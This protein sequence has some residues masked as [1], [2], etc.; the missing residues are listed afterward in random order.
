MFL[1]RQVHSKHES[2][3]NFINYRLQ[4]FYNNSEL[5]FVF[6][7]AHCKALGLRKMIDISIGT[8]IEWYKEMITDGWTIAFFLK[9]IEFLSKEKIFNRIDWYDWIN[10]M[11]YSG[12]DFLYL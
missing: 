6:V 10:D 3:P 9:R 1:I 4:P 2:L 7:H 11:A 8:I 12:D 5:E